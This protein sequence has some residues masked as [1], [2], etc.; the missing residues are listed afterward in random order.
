M[1]T[2]LE[3][4]LVERVEAVEVGGAW[5]GFKSHRVPG[6]HIWLLDGNEITED[7]AQALIAGEGG[8]ND[9]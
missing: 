2:Y 5:S 4:R 1:G 7:E 9:G 6:R 3:G 8:D